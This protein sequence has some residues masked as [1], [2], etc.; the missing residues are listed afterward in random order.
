MHGVLH[1]LV[2]CFRPAITAV[3]KQCQENLN[4]EQDYENEA[5]LHISPFLHNLSCFQDSEGFWNTGIFFGRRKMAL[6]NEGKTRSERQA[7]AK[8][9]K[10]SQEV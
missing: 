5:N 8:D 2:L 3:S 10:A 9:Q 6:G 4:S 1:S 7:I